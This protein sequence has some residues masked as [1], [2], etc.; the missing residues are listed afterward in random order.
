MIK[1]FSTFYIDPNGTFGTTDINR[2]I[3]VTKRF[4]QKILLDPSMHGN[5]KRNDISLRTVWI[6][7]AEVL[8]NANECNISAAG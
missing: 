2:M 3:T 1:K 4:C 6:T 5:D 7:Q 8:K